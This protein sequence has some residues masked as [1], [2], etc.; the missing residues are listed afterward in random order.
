MDILRLP[1]NDKRFNFFSEGEEIYS[2][3]TYQSVVVV[4][5][6][7]Y[8]NKNINSAGELYILYIVLNFNVIYE[9]VP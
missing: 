1:R 9:K 5:K 4:L 6:P 8:T 2:H 3:L 7:K